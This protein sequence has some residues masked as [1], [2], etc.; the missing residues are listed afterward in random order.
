MVNLSSLIETIKKG[1]RIRPSKR[2]PIEVAYQKYKQVTRSSILDWLIFGLFAVLLL[3]PSIVDNYAPY[4]APYKGQLMFGGYIIMLGLMVGATEIYKINRTRSRYFIKAR[5]NM[6]SRPTFETQFELVPDKEGTLYEIPINVDKRGFLEFVAT[7]KKWLTQ[8]DKVR[9]EEG[10]ETIKGKYHAYFIKDTVQNVRMI[11]L[12]PFEFFKGMAFEKGKVTIAGED[13]DALVA[14]VTLDFK[15]KV[16]YKDF[17]EELDDEGKAKDVKLVE[18]IIDLFEVVDSPWHRNY[19]ME[20]T[21]TDM[22]AR[23]VMMEFDKLIASKYID[24]VQALWDKN[25]E[26]QERLDETQ[27][28]TVSLA[29][30]MATQETEVKDQLMLYGLKD[31]DKRRRNERLEDLFLGGIITAIIFFVLLNLGIL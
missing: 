26:L 10:E 11:W 14:H 21:I 18:Q 7:K 6:P 12:M 2:P 3:L 17:E 1:L 16:P 5:I 30:E 19:R 31:L 13:V 20:R 27:V 24:T 29:S 9:I 28:S 8:D 23:E 4:L 15:R 22:E 25:L